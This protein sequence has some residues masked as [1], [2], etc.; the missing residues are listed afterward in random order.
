MIT[1][2]WEKQRYLSQTR[3]G[4]S[5]VSLPVSPCLIWAPGTSLGIVKSGHN[6]TDPLIRTMPEKSQLTPLTYTHTDSW[7]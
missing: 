1:V 5:C 4:H 3:A 6:N 2:N 7:L